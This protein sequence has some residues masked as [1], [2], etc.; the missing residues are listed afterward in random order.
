[1]V[2]YVGTGGNASNLF[3]NPNP[4]W[5]TDQWTNSAGGGQSHSNL[6]PYTSVNMWKRTA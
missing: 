3:S 6:A 4:Q 5:R 1:M 2:G